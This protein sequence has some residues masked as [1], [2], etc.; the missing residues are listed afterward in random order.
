MEPPQDI[1]PSDDQLSAV[2]QMY[3]NNILPCVE[4]PSSDRMGVVHFDVRHTHRRSGAQTLA[5]RRV[6]FPG[7]SDF[8]AWRRSWEVFKCTLLML[9]ACEIELLDAYSDFIRIPRIKYGQKHWFII[10][11]PD[12]RLMS[13]AFE[14]WVRQEEAK[15]PLSDANPNRKWDFLFM[16][17]ANPGHPPASAFWAEEVKDEVHASSA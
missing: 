7:P 10:Y 8:E 11:Q 9:D 16:S 12:A 14:Q 13:E 2:K 6:E 5:Y 15:V 1:E 17:A 3:V 4:F